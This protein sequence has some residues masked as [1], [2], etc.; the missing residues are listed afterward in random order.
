[1]NCVLGKITT[2]DNKELNGVFFNPAQRN[3]KAL[4]YIQ[5]FYG[6]SEILNVLSDKFE[7][8]G[9]GLACFDVRGSDNLVKKHSVKEKTSSLEFRNSVYDIE[10]GVRII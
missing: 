1:M 6:H 10:A 5:G 2:Y 9:Y 8:K 3:K 4:L 7:Q